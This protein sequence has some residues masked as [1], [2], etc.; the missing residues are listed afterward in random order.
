MHAPLPEMPPPRYLTRAWCTKDTGVKCCLPF[1]WV[2][3]AQIEDLSVRLDEAGDLLPITLGEESFTPGHGHQITTKAFGPTAKTDPLLKQAR[4]TL[5]RHECAGVLFFGPPLTADSTQWRALSLLH[6]LRTGIE[7]QRRVPEAG[8][9]FFPRLLIARQNGLSPHDL[10]EM[11]TALTSFS[12]VL[13]HDSAHVATRIPDFSKPVWRTV[14]LEEGTGDE[15]VGD[16]LPWRSSLQRDSQRR[17]I[18]GALSREGRLL[19]AVEHRR[20]AVKEQLRASR[21]LFC[22]ATRSGT[23][24][25]EELHTA[26]VA[27][28][29]LPL[30]WKLF[31]DTPRLK[32]AERAP[33]AEFSGPLTLAPQSVSPDDFVRGAVTSARHLVHNFR[34]KGDVGAMRTLLANLREQAARVPGAPLAPPAHAS[35]GSEAARA[36]PARWWEEGSAYC[37]KAAGAVAR[38]L[39]AEARTHY[40]PETSSHPDLVPLPASARASAP[41]DVMRPQV[42]L[43]GA[44]R[45]LLDTEDEEEDG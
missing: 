21:Q 12:H 27:L 42:G 6:F 28:D 26:T 14:R 1:L 35:D 34:M 38:A 4:S 9:A 18:Y 39:F 22:I 16:R 43:T 13:T 8:F 24:V 30:S 23:T 45:V 31:Q 17:R 19:R 37:E 7:G 44:A 33:L 11:A 3:A 15:D 32:A 41:E 29:A 10:E 20:H 40:W 25:Q 36:P 5:L 2:E